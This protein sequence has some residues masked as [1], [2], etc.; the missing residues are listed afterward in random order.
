VGEQPPHAP[1][2]TTTWSEL[3]ANLFTRLIRLA[4]ASRSDSRPAEDV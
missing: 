2:V 1:V 3:Q 4:I